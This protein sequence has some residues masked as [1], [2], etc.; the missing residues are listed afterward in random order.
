MGDDILLNKIIKAIISPMD[1]CPLKNSIN[2]I[3]EQITL[4]IHL[5]KL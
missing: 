4:G 2:A 5:T 3:R 1:N